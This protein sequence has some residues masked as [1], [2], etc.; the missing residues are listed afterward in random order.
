MAPEDASQPSPEFIEIP[1]EVDAGHEGFR[2][3]RYLVSCFGRLSRNRV[4]TMIRE[5]RV[6]DSEGRA[7]T[8]PSTRVRLGLALVVS[9]PAP[10]EPEIEV[11]YTLLYEDAD[12]LVIDKPPGL[13]VHASARYHKNTLTALMRDKLG[14]GHGWE[15]AHRLDRE[16]SGVMVFG[17]QGLSGPELKK[18]FFRREVRKEYL[19]L[20]AGRLEGE[21]EVD[22]A[23]GPALD[24]QVRIKVGPRSVD[25]GGQEASTRVEAL[26]WGEFRNQTC[27]LVRASPRTGRTHQIRVHLAEIGHAILGDKLYGGDESLFIDVAEGRRSAKEVEAELGLSRHALHAHTLTLPHPQHGA[28]V[29]FEAPWPAELHEVLALPGDRGS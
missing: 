14:A 2:L 8:K 15:M 20:V 19:A 27:T 1:L 4:L 18:S 5:G 13:P 21:R 26:A 24:S 6:R 12:L 29:R 22:I 25:D 7:L 16:T 11:D 28:L 23:L 10:S 9:R 17:R 3:D